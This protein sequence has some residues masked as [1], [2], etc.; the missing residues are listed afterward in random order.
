MYIQPLHICLNGHVVPNEYGVERTKYCLQCGEP[1]VSQCQSCQRPLPIPDEFDLHP[2]A[3]VHCGHCGE[4]H[5]WTRRQKQAAIGLFVEDVG[6]N[7]D[8]KNFAA[9]LEHISR[10]TPKAQLAAVRINKLL[11]KLGTGT[12]NLIRD[13]VVGVA[14]AVIADQIR[15][16]K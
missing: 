2:A 12:A 14:S 13:I 11:A 7:D 9:E 15:N 5:E 10:D 6:D 16:N 8:A 1:I 3:P 4:P